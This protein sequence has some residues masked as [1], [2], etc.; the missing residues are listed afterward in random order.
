MK[1]FAID[2]SNSHPVMF[3][4]LVF[5]IAHA[6]L[7]YWKYKKNISELKG[8]EQRIDYYFPKNGG[9]R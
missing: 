9:Q 8:L 2:F 3:L 1:C 6:G 7:I 5:L 4:Q